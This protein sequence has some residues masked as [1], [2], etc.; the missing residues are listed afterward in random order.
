MEDTKLEICEHCGQELKKASEERREIKDLQINNI[1]KVS[2]ALSARQEKLDAASVEMLEIIQ[3]IERKVGA[4][5]ETLQA[6][7]EL[8]L[9]LRKKIIEE[10][11]KKVK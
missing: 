11:E 5:K 4:D 6:V 3:R 10:S 9:K 8:E 1:D 2:K 7:K